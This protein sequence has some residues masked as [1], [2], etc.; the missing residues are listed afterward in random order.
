MD[1]SRVK[2]E[3]RFEACVHSL[4]V[5]YSQV[6]S[7]FQTRQSLADRYTGWSIID[8]KKHVCIDVFIFTKKCVKLTTGVLI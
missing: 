4:L 8:D 6:Y 3:V 2:A 7:I 5:F 1:Y